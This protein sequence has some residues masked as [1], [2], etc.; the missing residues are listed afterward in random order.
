MMMALQFHLMSSAHCPSG[1]P[2]RE[3][4]FEAQPAIIQ[5]EIFQVGSCL[6]SIK[7]LSICGFP[8]MKLCEPLCNS[9]QQELIV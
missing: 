7:F 8:L 1:N 3:K 2:V 4:T 6:D 9:V 5:E